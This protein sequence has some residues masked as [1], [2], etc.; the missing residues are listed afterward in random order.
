MSQHGIKVS[1]E[2]YLGSVPANVV[3]VQPLSWTLLAKTF[4]ETFFFLEVMHQYSWKTKL[5]ISASDSNVKRV[6][7]L[8][9]IFHQNTFMTDNLLL[10][11]QNRHSPEIKGIKGRKGKAQSLRQ[12][13]RRGTGQGR[14]GFLGGCSWSNSSWI[15]WKGVTGVGTGMWVCHPQTH[16]GWRLHCFGQGVKPGNLAHYEKGPVPA[17]GLVFI[18]QSFLLA[19]MAKKKKRW[20]R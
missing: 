8:S 19:L 18:T 9:E 5:Q 1:S 11:I 12:S 7:K 13:R 6:K 2:S 3:L 16:L 10:W 4:Y 15:G 17:L 20:M 14:K